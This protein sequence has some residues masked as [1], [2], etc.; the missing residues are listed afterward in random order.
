MSYLFD[1]YIEERLAQ[2]NVKLAPIP[3]IVERALQ[4]KPSPLDTGNVIVDTIRKWLSSLDTPTG[5]RSYDQTRMHEMFLS[6]VA[7]NIY[8]QAYEMNKKRIMQRNGW[9]DVSPYCAIC[10]PRRF[11]KTWALA[12]FVAA[13]AMEL[14]SCKICI[15]STGS[16]A[17]GSEDGM[18]SHVKRNLKL[19]NVTKFERD[20][21]EEL[22][23]FVNG[24]L[25]QIRGYP[26]GRDR[27]VLV[28]F[29]PPSPSGGFKT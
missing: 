10:T 9:S 27:Y 12:S 2:R 8:G 15:Y 21:P 29:S 25:R 4:L 20:N 14:P 17:S 19:F 16:R 11:G 5:G 26:G 3:T 7:R 24:N 18:L 6:A 1:A 23:F 28:F 22:N 13:L